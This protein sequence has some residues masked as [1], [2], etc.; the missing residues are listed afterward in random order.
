MRHWAGKPLFIGMVGNDKF[1]HFLHDSLAKYHVENRGI[2]FTD[3]GC[4]QLTFVDIDETGDRSFNFA[5]EPARTPWL[6][7]DDIDFHRLMR[8]KDFFT[9]PA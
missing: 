3:A 5:K 2:R 7:V 6:T 1:G 4:T 8:P 9:R